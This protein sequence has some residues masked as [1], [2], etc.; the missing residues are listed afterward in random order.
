MATDGQSGGS[1]KARLPVLT[2]PV[3][4]AS[5][6]FSISP[7]T[8]AKAATSVSAPSAAAASLSTVQVSAAGSMPSTN[9]I[10]MQRP[11]PSHHANTFEDFEAW[12]KNEEGLRVQ[13]RKS[14]WMAARHD[15]STAR[16]DVAGLDCE[17]NLEPRMKSLRC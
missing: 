17:V 14:E 16:H 8:Q 10:I 13:E 5:A 2:P 6:P 9:S 15:A 7:G 1:G 11:Q 4:S 12:M 3:S